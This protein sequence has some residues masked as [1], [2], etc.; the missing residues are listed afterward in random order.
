MIDCENEVGVLYVEHVLGHLD[1]Y[2]RIHPTIR[3]LTYEALD[4]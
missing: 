1:S 3:D 2:F 4:L